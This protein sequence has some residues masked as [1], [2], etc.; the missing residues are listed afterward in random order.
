[1]D[2]VTA[3]RWLITGI[4]G[5]LG[6]ALADAALAMGDGVAGTSR[7]AQ[8][9]RAFEARAPGR[10]IGIPLDAGDPRQAGEIV[11]RAIDGLGGIDLLVNNAGYAQAGAVEA[12]SGEEAQAQFDANFFGPVAL[13]RAALPGLIDRGGRILNISSLAAVET[14]AGLGHYCASKAALSAISESTDTE[15]APLGVRCIAVEPG[16]MRTAFAGSSL[17]KSRARLPR[18]GEQDA[19][20]DAS[21]RKSDGRQS[22]DPARIAQLLL[23]LAEMT[24][25]PSRMV[26]DMAALDRVERAVAKRLDGYRRAASPHDDIGFP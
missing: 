4:S 6:S 11:A 25:P 24:D 15:V 23:R 21:F 18:Y 17:R 20:Q 13:I 22:G 10:A 8:A 1:M 26:L 5:G 7:N 2:G 12:V 14:Y 16:G 3:R 19:T 9:A